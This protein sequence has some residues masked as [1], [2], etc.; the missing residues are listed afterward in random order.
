MGAKV[1]VCPT[2]VEASDPRSYY[3]VSKRISEETKNSWYV[4]QYNNPSNT[5]AHYEST[6]PEIWDQTD[7]KLII[8]SWCWDWGTISGVGKFL[9]E[10]N[11][12]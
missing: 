2:D 5:L 4:N 7:G 12:V 6:G 10:K 8:F 9:K 11:P 3:S 1:V